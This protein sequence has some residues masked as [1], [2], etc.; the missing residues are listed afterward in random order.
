VQS[1]HPD[2]TPAAGADFIAQ[3]I[4]AIASNPEVWAKTV[5]ILNY[6]ENDGLFDHVAPPSPPLGADEEFVNGTAIG[7]GF[8]VP[9][10]I[11]SPWTSGGYVC[12]QTFDHTSVLQFLEKFTGVREENITPWRR[13]TFGDL[14]AAFRFSDSAVPAH[15]LP[16]A[17]RA[18]QV[19]LEQIASLPKPVP[20]S[21]GQRLPVQESGE[22][23]SA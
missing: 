21:T 10:T 17:K 7:A 4:D 1:E 22:R 23:K 19:S 9:C 6:D 18:L 13:Q 20:P 15:D 8:R 11:V 16:D 5:F 14:T 3:K 12:S 2:F